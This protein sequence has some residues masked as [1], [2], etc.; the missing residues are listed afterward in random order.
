MYEA[1]ENILTWGEK[2]IWSFK[3]VKRQFEVFLTD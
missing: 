1:E 3:I 2:K